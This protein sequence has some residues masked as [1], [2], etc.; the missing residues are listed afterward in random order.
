MDK[1]LYSSPDS[2]EHLGERSQVID[3]RDSFLPYLLLHLLDGWR[4]YVR[5]ITS[6]Q[7]RR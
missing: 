4:Q 2:F 5:V 1:V 6:E 7:K 3:L